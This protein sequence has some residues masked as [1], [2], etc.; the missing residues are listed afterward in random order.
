[1][2][3]KED[4]VALMYNCDNIFTKIDQTKDCQLSLKEFEDYVHKR[5]GGGQQ[6]KDSVLEEFKKIDLARNN[7][8]QF[9]EFLR[10]ACN[11]DGI[12]L[13]YDLTL[14]DRLKL[15]EVIDYKHITVLEKKEI[16]NDLT[17]L[18]YEVDK[19]L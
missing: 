9:L 10:A 18:Q 15:Y 11:K 6:S 16:I 13:P 14:Y 4:L 2:E 8:I 1:M 19:S 7:Y 12:Y 17:N 5:Q 3:V